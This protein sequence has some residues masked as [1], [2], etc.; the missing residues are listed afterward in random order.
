MSSSSGNPEGAHLPT[1]GLLVLPNRAFPVTTSS[2]S[3]TELHSVLFQ[4]NGP[5]WKHVTTTVAQRLVILLSLNRPEMTIFSLWILETTKGG[6]ERAKWAKCFP[7][8]CK[9]LSSD[10]QKLRKAGNGILVWFQHSFCEMVSGDGN[11]W[12]L[13]T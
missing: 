11:V 1:Q 8:K 2:G 3:R 9:D 10:L 6:R 13:Q 4:G 12:K 7:G 5:L